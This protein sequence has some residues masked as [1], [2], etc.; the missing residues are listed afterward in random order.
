[1]DDTAGADTAALNL[2]H[3]VAA[4][5]QAVD[6]PPDLSGGRH[7]AQ[8]W[9][10][11]SS[12]SVRATQAGADL[13]EVSRIL[14]D[15]MPQGSW[16]AAVVRKPTMCERR[17]WSGWLAYR[18]GTR[19]PT[20]HSTGRGA[21]GTTVGA[22]GQGRGH[23]KHL[24]QVLASSLPGFDLTTWTRRPSTLLP[25]LVLALLGAALVLAGV[26]A[27]AMA[28]FVAGLGFKTAAALAG[29]HAGALTVAGGVV[30]ALAVATWAGLVPVR[31]VRIRR[32]LARAR[33]P[34]ARH[35]ITPPRKP[36]RVN[37]HEVEA[38]EA[39][40]GGNYPLKWEAFM[41]RPHIPASIV[42]PHSGVLSG[43]ASTRQR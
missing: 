24:L 42:A 11:R 25:G 40:D 17:W 26:N 16:V 32:G 33:L 4:R 13:A 27:A 21:E 41:L 10:R 18:M 12:A 36:G 2:S 43:I 29:T 30:G 28:A 20:H 9:W 14:G 34:K 23:A 5:L 19:R 15:V 7:V 1:M 8:L 3:C 6:E 37:T 22:G 38:E 31:A 39:D 35:R